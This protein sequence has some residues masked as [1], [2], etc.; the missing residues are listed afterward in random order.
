MA[1]ESEA[2]WL[3]FNRRADAD[4]SPAVFGSAEMRQAAAACLERGELVDTVFHNLAQV[5]GA[6][7]LQNTVPTGEANPQLAPDPAKGQTLLEQ[8]G[9]LAGEPRVDAD[10]RP[11]SVNYLIL[12]DNI[13]LAAAQSV[14]LL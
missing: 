12:N 1:S 7:A 2:A 13:N 14:K 3:L 9:W 4:G 11:L 6:I 5:P 8:A 10:G